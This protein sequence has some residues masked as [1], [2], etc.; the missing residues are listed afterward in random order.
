MNC[1][2]CNKEFEGNK[3]GTRLFCSG[4]CN[5]KYS[6]SP[7]TNI[8]SDKSDI[9]KSDIKEITIKLEEVCTP[10][11][12]RMYPAMCETKKQQKESIYRLDHN[13][14]KVLREKG[15]FIPAK[16]ANA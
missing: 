1:K 9:I 15:I 10:D 11:E 8:I 3:N 4:L 16:Y 6:R 5:K 12:L 14:I 7:K 13:S 2:Q